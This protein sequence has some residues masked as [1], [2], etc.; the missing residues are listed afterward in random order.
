MRQTHLSLIVI[1]LGLLVLSFADSNPAAGAPAS[2]SET[3]TLFLGGDVMTGRGIDQVLPHPVDSQLFESFLKDARLYVDLAEAANGPIPRPVD[4]AYIWGFALEELE[5]R[6]P[7]ARIINLETAVTLSTMYQR[8]KDIHYRMNPR[9]VTCLTAANIDVCVLGN[10]HILDWG[11]NGL[12]E[13]LTTLGEAGMQSTGAFRSL[14]SA[15]PAIVELGSRGRVLV[16][17]FGSVTSGIPTGWQASK[18]KPGVNLLTDYSPETVQRISEQ[19]QA[20]KQSGDIVV[21]S[22]HWGSNWGF[23][24]SA[25]ESSTAAGI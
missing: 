21:A 5:R 13:T 12:Q 6:Q 20:V 7:V 25:Q 9:N 11:A 2:S 23:E 15:V 4:P 1:C 18:R 19:I 17:S 22:I 16:F 24:I 10:N 14:K 8:S 3:I